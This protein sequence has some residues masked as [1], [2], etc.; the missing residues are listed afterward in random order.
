V[1]C[2]NYVNSNSVDSKHVR[3]ASMCNVESARGS[4]G[5]IENREGGEEREVEQGGPGLGLLSDLLGGL[6]HAAGPAG[7]LVD[8]H[9]PVVQL[10]LLL[11]RVFLL[12]LLALPLVGAAERLLGLRPRAETLLLGALDGL[13]GGLDALPLRSEATALVAH[14]LEHLEAL[15]AAGGG[16]HDMPQHAPE[17]H[18]AACSFKQNSINERDSPTT[19]SGSQ[20][21]KKLI[22]CHKRKRSSVCARS[23]Q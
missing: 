7:L 16:C 10:L 12:R 8:V 11:R 15:A 14:L 1:R 5:V 13:D 2:V 21:T 6:V 9:A 17:L 19:Q 20:M 22:Y 3:A 4:G 23:E 18:Q